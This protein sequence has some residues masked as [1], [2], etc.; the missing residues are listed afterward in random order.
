[1][2]DDLTFGIELELTVPSRN[3]IVSK[4]DM[5]NY[6]NRHGFEARCT[7]YADKKVTPYWKIVSDASV[8]CSRDDPHC[9][10][11][12]LV[13]PVL[14][15]Q[16]GLEMVEAIMGVLSTLRVTVNE[17]IG[18]HVHVGRYPFFSI[19]EKNLRQFCQI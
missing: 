16:R 1:V 2:P 13:S 7:E 12:E 15:G 4:E 14:R 8:C 6:L 3:Q 11:M 5:A 19:D 18:F 10:T 9:L 17:S